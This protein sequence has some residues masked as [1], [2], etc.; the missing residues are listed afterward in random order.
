MTVGDVN[1]PVVERTVLPGNPPM[2]PC[3]FCGGT[4]YRY[5]VWG[6]VCRPCHIAKLQK[7][8]EKADEATR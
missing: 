5:Y 1:T 7:A 6:P 8:S 4:T 2:P 3:Q